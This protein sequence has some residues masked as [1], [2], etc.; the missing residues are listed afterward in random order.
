MIRFIV[1]LVLYVIFNA[2]LLYLISFYLPDWFSV[3]STEY[4]VYIT[5]LFLAIVFFLSNTVLKKILKIVTFP[6]KYLTLWL[7][8]LLVNVFVLYVFE[9]IINTGDFGIEV[10]LW[11]LKTTF[12]MSIGIS[13]LFFLYKKIK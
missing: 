2:V 3:S 11:S 9:Y 4:T 10:V 7:S 8:T 5:F 1:K 6:L 13:V 12:V